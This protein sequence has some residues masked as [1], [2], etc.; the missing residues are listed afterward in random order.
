[1]DPIIFFTVLTIL[2]G[3][4]YF[5]DRFFKSCMHYPYDAFLRNTGL[6]VN[7]MSLHWHSNASTF[8]RMLIRWGSAAGKSYTRSFLVKCFNVGVLLSFLLLPIGIILLIITIFNGSDGGAPAAAG[9]A[10]ATTSTV[11]TATVQLEIL[12][13]GVNLPLQEIGYY[14]ATLVLCTLLHEM[15]HAFAAVLEDVPVTGFGFRIY[16]CLP[17]AYTELSHDHLNSLR[18]FRKLRILCAGIWNNFVFACVCYLFISTL[19]IIMSPFY[20]YNEHVIVTELTAKS[21]LRGDRGL[22]VQ[23]VITQLN[24]CPVS[25]EDSWLGCLQQAQQQRL[26]YCISSDFIRLN[27]ESIDIAHHNAEG[28][29]QCCDERNPNVSCF[30]YIEDATVDAPAEIPQHVC[31]PMRRT[32]EDSSGYCRA[33][34]CAQ[35]YCLR[36][37]LQNTTRILVFKR[38]S[39]DHEALPPVM[40]VGQPRD[41]LRSVRVSAFVP[42]YKQISSA[43]PDALSLLLRYNVVF[44]IGLAL[45]NAIPC[46]GFDG[47]H[48]TSTVIHSFLV[49]RVEEHPKRDLISLIITSVGSLLFG[50]ALLKV[51]WLSL[52]RPLL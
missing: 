51:A 24:D 6:N 8:N 44:S 38:Q 50:L 15:G 16:F 49:G 10:A 37:M 14:I 47:A 25:N 4:M 5:F 26:G 20:Q 35:G 19:G 21:P 34:S 39:L 27:D 33:G 32:L 29:L 2:Y 7:F 31:L 3:V 9:G 36:P 13:P 1:M 12:L 52:L 43:W 23:N 18:W 11:A 45:I 28:R 46:F 41:V 42:R 40:Y 48:I 17:L 30:E 22:Q